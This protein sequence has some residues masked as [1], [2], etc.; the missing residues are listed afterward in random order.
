MVVEHNQWRIENF[1]CKPADYMR[2]LTRDMVYLCKRDKWNHPIVVINCQAILKEDPDVAAMTMFAVFFLDFVVNKLMVP[3]RVENI[4]I[5]C[6]L[7][8]IGVT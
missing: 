8:N 2:Y 7:A 6:D 3:S 5:I 4:M 1:P